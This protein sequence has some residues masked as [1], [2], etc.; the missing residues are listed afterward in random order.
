MTHRIQATLILLKENNLRKILM[1]NINVIT[2]VSGDATM[3]I[4]KSPVDVRK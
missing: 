2:F 1:Q 3:G 4:I